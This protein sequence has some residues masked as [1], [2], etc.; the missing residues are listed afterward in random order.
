MARVK[1]IGNIIYNFFK[2]YSTK[3]AALKEASRMRKSTGLPARVF[4]VDKHN[5]DVYIGYH[6]N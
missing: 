4:T 6:G 1:K 2:R 3:K 5:H